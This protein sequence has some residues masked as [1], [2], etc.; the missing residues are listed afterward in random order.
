MQFAVGK[1]VTGEDGDDTPLEA[2]VTA[3][4]NAMVHYRLI[5]KFLMYASPGLARPRTCQLGTIIVGDSMM[6]RAQDNS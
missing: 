4:E 3:D 2:R 5:P 1:P 6:E